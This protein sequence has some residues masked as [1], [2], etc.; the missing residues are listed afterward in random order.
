MR[1]EVTLLGIEGLPEIS[2]GDNLGRLIAAA[3]EAQ[4]TPLADRD[5]LV[6]TQ[7]VVSKA[8][9]RVVDLR[10]VEPSPRALEFAQAWEKDARAVEVILREA[11]RV[12]RMENGVLI[13]ETSHGFICANSG[14]DASN[15]GD[16]GH[17]H[18]VLLP[19]DADASASA[20]RR[21]LRETIGTDVAVI[22]SDTFGRPWREGALNVAI[23]VAGIEPLWD[24]RGESDS[25]GRELRSTVIAVAD[26]IA[27]ASELVMNKLTRVP[28][29]IVRGYPYLSGESGIASVV[30]VREKDLFR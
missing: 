5:V 13:T 16:G 19:V 2:A 3:A 1:S 12:V 28:A 17:D 29:A 20:I 4:G 18:V 6:V 9:G 24:Y 30:R 11:A 23:G 22:V 7:K 10:T 14:V 25:D 15:V 27:A 21:T 26:E 8:E